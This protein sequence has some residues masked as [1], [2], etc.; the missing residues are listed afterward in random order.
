MTENAYRLL[1]LNVDIGSYFISIILFICNYISLLSLMLIYCGSGFV[2]F[3][4]LGKEPARN[5]IYQAI[6]LFLKFH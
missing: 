1:F 4:I 3:V 2:H 6:F 5:M